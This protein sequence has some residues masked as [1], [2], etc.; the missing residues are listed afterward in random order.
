MSE[1]QKKKGREKKVSDET[2]TKWVQLVDAKREKEGL[3][4]RAACM[5]VSKELKTDGHPSIYNW[6]KA[7]LEGKDP[8]VN[9]RGAFGKKMA[10]EAKSVVQTVLPVGPTTRRSLVGP[11]GNGVTDGFT[12]SPQGGVKVTVREYTFEGSHEEVLNAVNSLK[13]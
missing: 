10:E 1:E 4:I 8:R 2:K 6:W 12:H 7:K 5:A 9:R 3:S 11:E 13:K